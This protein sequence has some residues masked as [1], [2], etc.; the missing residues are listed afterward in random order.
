MASQVINFS[1]LANG[2]VEE[3]FQQELK[4][5]FANILDPNT[6]SKTKRTLTLTLTISPSEARNINGVDF[7]VKSKLASVKSVSSAFLIDEDGEG[8][9]VSSELLKQVPG[10]TTIEG[11]ETPTTITPVAQF[12]AK[13]E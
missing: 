12:R 6:E 3:R 7:S 5:V 9:I 1:T 11:T 13:A 4:N 8:K 10:Q 2:A